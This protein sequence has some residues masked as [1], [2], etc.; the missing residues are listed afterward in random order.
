MR[1]T[2]GS[3][4]EQL[5]LWLRFQGVEGPRIV[6]ILSEVRAHVSE[7]GENPYETFGEPRLYA[8]AFAEGSRRRWLWGISLAVAIAAFLASAY[9]FASDIAA[10]RD[11]RRLPLGGHVWLVISIGIVTAIV[12][13]RAVLVVAVRPLSALAY[14]ESDTA[15]SWKKWAWRRRIATAA[16]V[17]VLVACSGLWGVALGNAYRDAPK[18]RSATYVWVNANAPSD[19][20]GE[21]QQL[22]TTSAVIYLSAPGPTTQLVGLSLSTNWNGSNDASTLIAFPTLSSALAAAHNHNFGTDGNLAPFTT[23]KYGTYYVLDYFGSITPTVDAPSPAEDLEANYSVEGVGD[24]TLDVGLP[25][26]YG[27]AN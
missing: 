16:V 20:N 27:D 17:V 22:I 9:M 11:F 2:T 13:W 23:L 24:D 25:I 26:N 7:S 15:T 18:L 21:E 12:A 14:E 10:H 5:S 3:Y 4:L 8:K 1:R 6:T 19:S